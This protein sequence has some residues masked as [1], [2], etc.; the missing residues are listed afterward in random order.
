MKTVLNLVVVM[1]ISLSIFTGYASGEVECEGIPDTSYNKP[2]FLGSKYHL[3][4]LYGDASYRDTNFF[5]DNYDGMSAWAEARLVFP[6][7]S[8]LIQTDIPLPD[9]FFIGT[10][11]DMKDIDWEDRFDY[12][13]GIEW[14]ILKKAGFLNDTILEWM[15]QLRFYVVYLET[16]FSH[17]KDEWDWRPKHDFRAGVDFYRECNLYN[18]LWYWG[19][20]WGDVSWR[21]TNFYVDDYKSWTFAF[22]PKLGIKLFPSSAFAP[23]PYATGEISLTERREFWQNRALAGLGL[24]LMP[25]RFNEGPIDVF[26]KGLRVYTEALWVAEYFKDD[27]TNGTPD[28]DYRVGINFTVNWW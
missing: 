13:A 22:V 10:I 18:K 26:I 6:R 12:G 27:A 25:F 19:E 15:K 28:H 24:Q 17:N 8:S 11:K 7:F 5:E 9:P 21:K 16:E 23:M 14:R 20:F 3:L 4:Q 2:T 1:F